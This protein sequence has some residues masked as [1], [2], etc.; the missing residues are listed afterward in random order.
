MR[1]L[2]IL[3]IFP[4][5]SNQQTAFFDKWVTVNMPYATRH[6]CGEE[7]ASRRIANMRCK[8]DALG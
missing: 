2:R 4:A 6:R 5:A 3:I 8:D 1:K 7:R